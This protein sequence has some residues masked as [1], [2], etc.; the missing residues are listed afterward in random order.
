ML[1]PRPVPTEVGHLLLE[2]AANPPA[3][4][5]VKLSQ[6]TDFQIGNAGFAGTTRTGTYPS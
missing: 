1:T 4:R 6:I 3:D 2:I 5:G